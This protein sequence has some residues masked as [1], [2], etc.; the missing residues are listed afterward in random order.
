[1]LRVDAPL[2]LR[3]GGDSADRSF[4]A[5]TRELPEWIFE[6]T[7]SW[8]TEVGRIV[9]RSDVRL[10]PQKNAYVVTTL[11]SAPHPGLRGVTAHRYPYSACSRPGSSTFPTVAGLLSENATASMARTALRVEHVSDRAGLPLWLTEI[12]S[13]TCGG[14]LGVSNTFATAPWA[15]DALFE[16]VRTGVES[17]SVHMRADARNMAFSLTTAGLVAH[18]LLYGMVPFART[19]GP[20]ARLIPLRVRAPGSLRL[21]A[22]AVEVNGPIL[23]VLLIDKSSRAARVWLDL[24]TT[25]GGVVQRL[26]AP[27]V[28][29]TSGVTL[30]GQRLDR[31]G[32]WHGTPT[33]ET[34]NKRRGGYPIVL[35]QFSA[36]LIKLRLRAGS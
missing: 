2:R 12:N 27:S 9:R 29:S 24:P 28:I 31:W 23:H 14:T 3:I 1:M 26:I 30:D 6:L 8:L 10:N 20:G 16:L 36:A 32:R 4:W 15:P 21:T 25:G 34:V 35:S 17:A 7:P 18:P 11:L 33:T 22:W 13:V 19:L 5:P